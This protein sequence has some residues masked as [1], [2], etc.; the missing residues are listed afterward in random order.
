MNW[1]ESGQI[2]LSYENALKLNL[3][4]SVPNIISLGWKTKKMYVYYIFSSLSL[5]L[6][7]WTIQTL[8]IP[9]VIYR[10]LYI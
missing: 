2:N 6:F 10:V 7:H 9:A 5:T 8:R 4:F 1:S 3:L